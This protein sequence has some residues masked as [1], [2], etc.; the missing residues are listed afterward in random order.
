MILARYWDV[1][2]VE[3]GCANKIGSVIALGTTQALYVYRSSSKWQMMV[4]MDS[5]RQNAC[6]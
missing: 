3:Q 2:F 6:G 5:Q 4:P 1:S